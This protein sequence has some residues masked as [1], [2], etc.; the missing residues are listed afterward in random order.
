MRFR[1]IPTPL[2]PDHVLFEYWGKNGYYRPMV[3]VLLH[4]R[5]CDHFGRLMQSR[6]NDFE[7]AIAER[8]RDNLCAAIMAVEARLRHQNA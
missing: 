1:Y 4:G 6:V 3:D 8:A 7:A 5:L 2:T